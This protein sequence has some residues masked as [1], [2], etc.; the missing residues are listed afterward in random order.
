MT[1]H[2]CSHH[3]ANGLGESKLALAIIFTILFVGGEMIAGAL[4]HSVALMADAGHNFT[5]A[6][7]LALSWY[8]LRIARRPASPTRTYGYHRAGI[9]AALFNASTLLIIAGLIAFESILRLIHPEHAE[10]RVMMVVAG[11]ALILNLTIALMLR[12]DAAHS[13]NMRSA[14]LHMAGDAAASLGVVFAGLI[15]HFTGW[16]QPDPIFSLG[17]ALFIGLSSRSIVSETVNILL[18]GAP[19]GVDVDKVA[20]SILNV[21]GVQDVHDLHVW[22]IGDGLTALSCH[23]QVMASEINRTSGIVHSVKRALLEEYAIHH[24]TIE[25][26]CEGCDTSERYCQLDQ[27]LSAGSSQSMEHSHP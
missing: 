27:P 23:L 5:D 4:A 7:A 14:F 18:E 8:A 21:N 2:Q 13:I 17:I 26:E 9:L 25:T 22:S 20:R 11:A 1:D 12:S 16:N 15:I 24:A 3:S 6:L 19:P 10:G